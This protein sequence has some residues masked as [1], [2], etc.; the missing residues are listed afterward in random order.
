MRTL[1]QT[2]SNCHY[3]IQQLD[4]TLPYRK[5]HWGSSPCCLVFFCVRV[6]G[7]V[8]PTCGLYMSTTHSRASSLV[9]SNIFS[10]H[11]VFGFVLVFIVIALVGTRCVLL[12]VGFVSLCGVQSTTSNTTTACDEAAVCAF[13]IFKILWWYIITPGWLH[14]D[15]STFLL[16]YTRARICRAWY[17]GSTLNYVS[18]SAL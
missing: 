14:F 8:Q 11:R 9:S 3:C 1:C 2:I 10:L 17:S 15:V 18:L 16:R 6:S 13:L 7:C 12:C 4:E 5:N